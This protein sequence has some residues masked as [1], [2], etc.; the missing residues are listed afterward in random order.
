MTLR[1]YRILILAVMMSFALSINSGT[2]AFFTFPPPTP[3]VEEEPV[4]QAPKVDTPLETLQKTVVELKEILTGPITAQTFPEIRLVNQRLVDGVTNLTS[5][6]DVDVALTNL[7]DALVAYRIAYVGTKQDVMIDH[8]DALT[9]SIAQN[10]QRLLTPEAILSKTRATLVTLKTIDLVLLPSDKRMEFAAKRLIDGSNRTVST[11]RITYTV[12]QNNKRNFTIDQIK[13]TPK[14]KQIFAY[15]NALQAD[16]NTFF[17][18]NNVQ[19][20]D[21]Q[22]IFKLDTPKEALGIQAT[23]ATDVAATLKLY[24]LNKLA[25]SLNDATATLP[26]DLFNDNKVV[27]LI[28]TFDYVQRPT[29]IAQSGYRNGYVVDITYYVDNKMVS[30]LPSPMALSFPIRRYDFDG[31]TSP[32]QLAI[33][34]FNVGKNAWLPVGGIYEPIGQTL[35]CFRDNLSQYTILKST[36]T[37][38]DISNTTAKNSINKL[39]NKG[40]IQGST[41]FNPKANITREEFVGWIAKAYGLENKSTKPLPFTDVSKTSPYYDAIVVVY[42]QGIVG[43]K[44]ATTFNPKGTVS[45]QEMAKILSTTLQKYQDKKINAALSQKLAASAK[46]LPTWSVGGMSLMLELGL[47]SDTDIKTN[48]AFVTKENAAN[49]FGKIY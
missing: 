22:I 30:T 47:Y 31:T 39:L 48:T 23:I 20:L 19:I 32:D 24:N 17:G 5:I 25:I 42:G 28:M 21:R 4:T 1:W 37:F 18:I 12:I 43:G 13:T 11:E 38:S 40:V 3:P 2:F 6:S 36:K 16:L 46:N 8:A 34:R 44:T 33:Y 35:T 49:V 10:T 29:A 15:H 26:L 14:A 41:T 7:Q 9:T 45:K 27:D